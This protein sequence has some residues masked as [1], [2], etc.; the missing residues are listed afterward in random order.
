[1]PDKTI[2]RL[3]ICSSAITSSLALHHLLSE[4]KIL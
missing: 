2:K 4:Q 1:M 3:K